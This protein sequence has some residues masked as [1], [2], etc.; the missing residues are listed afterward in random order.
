MR[1]FQEDGWDSHTSPGIN[2]DDPLAAQGVD[3]DGAY[4]GEDRP[5]MQ[6]LLHTNGLK[7]VFSGHDHGN[8]WCQKWDQLYPNVTMAQNSAPFLC[9]GRH[10]GYGGYGKWMRGSRQIKVLLNEDKHDAEVTTWIRLEDGSIS[11]KVN[12]N[13]TFGKDKYPRVP[14]KYSR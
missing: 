9:F 6:A 12:L 10:T 5:F 13:S 2:D 3:A 1:V 14:S 7:A 4:T 11:G 8:D